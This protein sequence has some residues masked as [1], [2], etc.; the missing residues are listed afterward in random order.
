MQSKYNF[1]ITQE[2]AYKVL[3][4]LVNESEGALFRVSVLSGGCSGFQYKFEFDSQ[5]KNNDIVF[6]K[7]DAQIVIDDISLSFLDGSQLDY[8]ETLGNAGFEIKNPNA[9]AKC[10]CGNSFSV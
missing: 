5:K 9:S 2:A 8:V 3:E 10:G 4:L 1:S 7:G 6:Q